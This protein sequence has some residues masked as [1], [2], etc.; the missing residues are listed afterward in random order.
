[1]GF[2]RAYENPC[3]GVGP[4][5][6]RVNAICPGSVDGDRTQRVLDMES[7]ASSQDRAILR[8]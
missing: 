5:G 2:Y 6:V 3:H 8:A 4:A 7:V 1:M